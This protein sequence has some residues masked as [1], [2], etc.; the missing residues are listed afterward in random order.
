MHRLEK[1]KRPTIFLAVGQ[2][3]NRVSGMD[4][5]NQP[6]SRQERR[7]DQRAFYV[8]TWSKCTTILTMISSIPKQVRRGGPKPGILQVGK[9]IDAA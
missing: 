1:T 8:D 5:N 2:K 9:Q 4:K 7:E 6:H 3:G